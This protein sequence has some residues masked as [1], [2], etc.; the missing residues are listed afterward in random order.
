MHYRHLERGTRVSVVATQQQK[1]HPKLICCFNWTCSVANYVPTCHNHRDYPIDPA[2]RIESGAESKESKGSG[3]GQ[4]GR[5]GVGLGSFSWAAS[6][7][8]GDIGRCPRQN[9]GAGF[10]P[11]RKRYCRKPANKLTADTCLRVISPIHRWVSLEGNRRSFRFTLSP[12]Q[13]FSY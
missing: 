1:Y 12:D 4:G 7:R 9:P 5:V 3:M 11:G 10:A 8:T 2:S 6:G 13:P